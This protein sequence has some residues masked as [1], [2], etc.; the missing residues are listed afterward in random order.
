MATLIDSYNNLKDI[1]GPNYKEPFEV[2]EH[3]NKLKNYWKPEKIKVI[4]LAESH[5]YTS[6]E[7]FSVSLN[8]SKIPLPDYPGNFVKYIYCLGYGENELLKGVVEKNPGTS[9]FWK[10]F[11]SC[12]SDIKEKPDFDP[13]LKTR[14]K[15][16]SERIKSKI[17]TLQK[18]KDRGIWLVDLS[19]VG[20]YIPGEPKPSI[21]LQNKVLSYCWEKLIREEVE[22][23]APEH[24]I[25]IGKG[26]GRVLEN[27]LS[28]A[29]VKSLTVLNQPQAKL[30]SKEQ[31]ELYVTCSNICNTL[32]VTV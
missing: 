20:L 30:S 28:A 7:E 27:M 18:L 19:I 16:F 24:L 12:V 10:I 14:N 2:I 23:A 31:L 13:V 1:L 9:Q 8:L 29:Q 15:N 26:V 4:L 17:S 5:V 11:H 3:V 25:I 22:E 32:K 21:K 6:K